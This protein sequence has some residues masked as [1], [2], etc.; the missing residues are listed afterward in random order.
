VNLF[1]RRR[2]DQNPPGK[3]GFEFASC[4]QLMA[5][6]CRKCAKS[7][8]RSHAQ[9]SSGISNMLWR[10]L[11]NLR[12]EFWP[13]TRTQ[14]IVYSKITTNVSTSNLDPRSNLMPIPA[15][16]PEQVS[17]SVP[18]RRSSLRGTDPN[19]FVCP[20]HGT[21][22]NWQGHVD[23]YIHCGEDQVSRDA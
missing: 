6:I 15:R 4:I 16:V 20:V 12:S 13:S 8:N 18:E 7:C 2:L 14:A 1:H 21:H 10:A 22:R 3:Y 19:D 23:C 11:P 17:A 9:N 5:M